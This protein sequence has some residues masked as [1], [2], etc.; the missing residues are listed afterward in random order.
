[1]VYSLINYYGFI[2]KIE[3]LTERPRQTPRT[4]YVDSRSSVR[5][6]FSTCGTVPATSAP[7][8][9]TGEDI[10]VLPSSHRV[11]PAKV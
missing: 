11:V 10:S 9:L 4:D 2:A 1:M 5:T 3:I 7:T 8:L 6:H